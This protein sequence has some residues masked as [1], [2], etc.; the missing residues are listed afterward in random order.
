VRLVIQTERITCAVYTCL[1]RVW[2][3]CCGWK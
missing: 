2:H 1:T 3:A